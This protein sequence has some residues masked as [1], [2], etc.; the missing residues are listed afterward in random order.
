M[1]GEP[2]D[3][4]EAIIAREGPLTAAQTLATTD[5]PTEQAQNALDELLAAG[6]VQPLDVS[7]PAGPL[8]TPTAWT[9]LRARLQDQLADYHRTNPLRQGMPREEMKNRLQPR[10]GWSTRLF[11]VIVTRTVADGA[12]RERGSLL[13]SPDFELRFSPAQQTAVDQLLA[14]FDANPYTPPTVKQSLEVVDE[15]VLNA[16]IDQNVLLRVAPDVLFKQDAY[17]QMVEMIRQHLQTH[18]KITVG[19]C[20]DMF[21]ASRKYMLGLLEY[22]DQQHLT[23]R[24]G[25]VRVLR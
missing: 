25:D 5:L 15:G 11:N 18:G 24:E 17:E 22:L 16:L 20:R 13:A 12:A 23:K 21:G 1:Q 3:I 6:R 7:Q 10:S 8:L 2:N 9:V 14:R 4:L 19:E